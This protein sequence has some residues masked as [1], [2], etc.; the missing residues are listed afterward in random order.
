MDWVKMMSGV[1]T[2]A[3]F[4]AGGLLAVFL[5]A[6]LVAAFIGMRRAEDLLKQIEKDRNV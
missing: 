6:M 4:I 5:L 3:C 2:L 1:F